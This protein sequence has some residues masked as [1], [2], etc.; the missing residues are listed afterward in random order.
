[1]TAFDWDLP[2]RSQR[3]AVLA[4]NVV[5]TSQP[6]AAQAG[7]EMMRAGGNAIDAAIAAAVALTVVEPVANGIG[8]DNF[9]LL[10]S[11]GT[12]HGLNASGRAPALMTPDN[13][14]DEIRLRGWDGVTVP[15]AV[16]GWIALHERFGTLPLT[17]LLAPAIRYATE[18]F[19]VS[20]QTG[21]LWRGA[22]GAAG[23]AETFTD[24]PA[25]CNTFLPG[26]RPPEPGDIFRNPDQARTLEEIAKT[27]GESFYRGALAA[28]IDA[29]ARACGGFIRAQDLAAHRADW[30]HPIAM[31]YS[32]HVLHELPPNGQGLVA[33]MALGI[34]AQFDL[35]S[36]APDTSDA[37]H[38]Q[39]E[40]IKV[41]FA[42]GHRH[43]A[44]PDH[45][46]VSVESLLNPDYLANRARLIDRER[47][48]DFD[49]GPPAPGGTVYLCTADAAGNMVS[50]IQS[51]Y[52]G[53]GSGVVIPG[54]GIAMHNRGCNFTLERGHANCL[55]PGKRPYHTIIPGFLSRDNSPLMAFGVMGGFMQPQGQLQVLLRLV[56][57][58]QNPQAAMDAPRFQVETGLVVAIEPGFEASVYDDLRARGHDLRV[59]ARTSVRFGRGQAIYRLGH[60]G[61]FGA[62]D[63]RAD[64]QAT[65][66]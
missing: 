65:G 62:S 29:H 1:M 58:D 5:A 36:M 54:T 2:Y 53:F 22:A 11:G 41:A 44:D 31:N 55:G 64:G 49:H 34:L 57:H 59:A 43:I 46:Q 15:G 33:L 26:G 4:R 47:A 13:Y 10:W 25:F 27:G 66:Y 40:A 63:S 32:G 23:A 37:L 38:L 9:A 18:G 6:L 42:D 14:R 3:E 60:G 56:D 19:I 45:M 51:N 48:Q 20:R 61:Y 21:E 52:R 30:V 8:G 35:A 39:I 24:F 12:L 7:L 28:K 16:S 17:L 50:M